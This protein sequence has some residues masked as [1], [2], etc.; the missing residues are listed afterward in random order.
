MVII[1]RSLLWTRNLPGGWGHKFPV[2][3]SSG[4]LDLL[5]QQ[6]AYS[7][8][9]KELPHFPGNDP[10]PIQPS[11]ASGHP[12]D[13]VGVCSLPR[14]CA[15]RHYFVSLYNSRVHS[16]HWGALL[17]QK[18]QAMC[19]RG[20][21]RGSSLLT[22]LAKLPLCP[23]ILRMDKQLPAQVRVFQRTEPAGQRCL[24]IDQSVD[25]YKKGF[26]M[27]SWLVH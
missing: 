2:L 26:S 18:N 11:H 14:S 25:R 20:H 6:Q 4:N 24:S 27:G 19:S 10:A 8:V 22:C 16:L 5:K 9:A 15:Y 17:M 1:E 21:C 3:I 23:Q 12:G 7:A 13:R